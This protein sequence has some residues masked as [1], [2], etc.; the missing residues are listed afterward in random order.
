M[1]AIIVYFHVPHGTPNNEV[2]N[3]RPDLKKVF[4]IL[5]ESVS[6]E[7]TS[8]PCDGLRVNSSSQVHHPENPELLAAIRSEEHTSE[9]QSHLNLVCRLLLE[10]K[11]KQIYKINPRVP[12]IPRRHSSRAPCRT[13]LTRR[14]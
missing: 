2:L 12:R 4:G 13:S 8:Y 14:L 10:K 7:R 9:L 6:A 3:L 5:V 1:G 11:K